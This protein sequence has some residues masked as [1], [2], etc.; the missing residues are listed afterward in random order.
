[1]AAEPMSV[2]PFLPGLDTQTRLPR[3]THCDYIVLGLAEDRCPECGQTIDWSHAFDDTE[4]RRPGSPVYQARGWRRIPAT[5]LTVLLMLFR[6]I[7][8]ARRLRWDEPIWPAVAVA[9]LASL[10]IASSLT[11]REQK[12]CIAGILACVL[13]NCLAFSLIGLS[14]SASLRWWQRL[15][16]FAVVSAYG[17]CFVAAWPLTGPPA[18]CYTEAEFLWPIDRFLDRISKL[19]DPDFLGRTLI[20]YWW[21]A[22]LL[23]VAFTRIRPRW[24][25]AMF[26]PVPA[27]AGSVACQ[28]GLWLY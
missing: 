18:V 13:L 7:T 1:M 8:F 26:V 16:L 20:F 15:R 12:S 25:A 22:I 10:A 4:Q 2:S 23:A 14:R 3:C 6:P 9:V 21:W 17:T 19:T 5:L 27:I 11:T 28:V 24:R